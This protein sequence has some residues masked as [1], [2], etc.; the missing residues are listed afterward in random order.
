VPM[1]NVGVQPKDTPATNTQPTASAEP[2][3][4]S[5]PFGHS[6]ITSTRRLKHMLLWLFVV[7]FLVFFLGYLAI[8]SGIISTSIN[9]PFHILGGQA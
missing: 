3:H 1:G 9:L 5:L 4:Q 6:P 8:E 2:H 7:A